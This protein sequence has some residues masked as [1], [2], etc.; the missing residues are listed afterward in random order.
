MHID[1]LPMLLFIF[2]Q[3]SRMKNSP[4]INAYCSVMILQ[5][6][7]RLVLISSKGTFNLVRSHENLALWLLWRSFLDINKMKLKNCWFQFHCKKAIQR[8]SEGNYANS[9]QCNQTD[10]IIGQSD[11]DF[12]IVIKQ[13]GG[14]NGSCQNYYVEIQLVLYFEFACETRGLNNEL[15]LRPCSNI[16]AV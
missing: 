12:S 10:Q 1:K 16:T 6:Y 5:C 3:R 7:K 11:T 8:K 9:C 13:F 4:K 14:L 2:N 15:N